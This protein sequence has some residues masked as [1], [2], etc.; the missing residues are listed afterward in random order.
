MERSF[1]PRRISLF[2]SLQFKD[3]RLLWTGLLISNLGSWMQLTA[4]GY[5]IAKL[6]GSAHTA[7]LYLGFQGL[8][9]AVPVL[10]LSPIAG[11]VA[12][13]WPRRR[14][15]FWTNSVMAMLALLLAVLTTLGLMNIVGL[16]L[17][18]A[19]TAA[20]M[21]F[22]A[23]ARQS[24]V[25]L[26]VPRQYIGNAIGLNSVAFNSPAV[27]GPAV[28]GILIASIGIAGSFYVNAVATLAVVVAL[29]FMEPAPPS[30]SAREP[31]LP[32]IAYGLRFLY[33]H[34]ILAWV[35]TVF[36][37]TAV[38]VRPYSTLLPAF[39]VNTLHANAKGL[40]IAIAATGVGGFAG[41]LLTA[42]LGSREQRGIIWSFSAI[43]MSLG[44]AGLGLIWNLWLTLPV[45]FII[46]TATM[47]FLGASNTLIQTLSPDDVR[48]RAIS[49]Y[50]MVA[51][52]LVPGGA[53]VVG[54]I[55][56]ILGLHRAFLIVGG[57]TAAFALWVY[58]SRPVLRTV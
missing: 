47:T 51:L 46:G 30:T 36:I 10:L 45:L 44:V 9:R 20:A 11:L 13:T 56:S 15:L 42:Y 39:V 7:S 57:V 22:D 37:A 33:T 53:L 16:I 48:G 26:M 58:V 8:A 25:P 14:I 52:G 43:V 3:F 24:W 35:I 41:A 17:I 40:G 55:G 31:F 28:A 5:F 38:L 34:R 6:A 18:N 29:L 21:S 12:D 23:P 1:P 54:A 49:V 32:S 19:A 50:S 2:A 4:T 27:V